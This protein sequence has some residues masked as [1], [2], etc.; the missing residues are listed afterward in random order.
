MDGNRHIVTSSK[1]M[2]DD[3]SEII[4]KCGYRPSLKIIDKRGITTFSRKRNKSF[5][6]R[7][8]IYKVG[9]L[10]SKHFNSIHKH[11]NVIDN[12]KG[13]V[14]CLQLKKNSTL[15][16]R[17]NGQS[18]WSGNCRFCINLYL[19]SGIGS[20]PKL[21]KVSELMANG[22]NI[23]RKTKDWK[24]TLLLPVHPNCR[25]LARRYMKGDIWDKETRMFKQ[26]ENYERK[27]VPKA[28]VKIQVGDKV[29]NV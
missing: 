5:T 15:Y 9:I 10:I 24:P 2:A 3:L 22:T 13:E 12:W 16:I 11:F 19:T 23:G 7:H 4:L 26:P 1:Q 20:E 27:V 6:T 17:R 29:F 21:F 25:C 8:L 18:I 14:G 28:R